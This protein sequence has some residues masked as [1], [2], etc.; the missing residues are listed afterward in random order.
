MNVMT[1]QLFSDASVEIIREASSSSVRISDSTQ[2]MKDFEIVCSL[3]I[4]GDLQGYLILRSMLP[5][6]AKFVAA[7]AAHLG[8]DMEE[9]N[10]GPLHKAAIAE[11]TNQI[12][13]RATQKL[14]EKG[15]DCNITPPTIIT[16]KNVYSEI[17]NLESSLNKKIE[18]DFGEF[19]LFVGIRNAKK[20]V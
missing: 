12:S 1:L 5:S 9:K 16:G 11:L 3:G 18:G 4:T 7:M 20:A 13:G 6:A 17:L 19:N 15:L 2:K 10:F 8:M 14:S